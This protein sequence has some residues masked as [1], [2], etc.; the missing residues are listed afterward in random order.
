M[1]R[2]TRA[3]IDK[4][5]PFEDYL[6]H[7][8]KL[9]NQGRS[10]SQ[11]EKY[12]TEEVLGYTKLNLARMTRIFKTA[13]I[14]Q[15][16]IKS[17]STIPRV[18][19]W[20]VISESWCG[21]AAQSVPVMAKIASLSPQFEFGILLRDEHPELIDSF[22]TKGA[23]AIPK[24]ICLDFVTLK[25]LGDWG[26]RPKPAQEKMVQWIAEGLE[27]H[28]RVEQIQKW[29]N[30]DKTVSIQSELLAKIEEWS[31]LRF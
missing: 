15:N 17:F 18:W 23:R 9:F 11:D 24:L 22:L 13:D 29:Y 1:F 6:H 26:P 5:I 19:I 10:T 8:E 16:I 27:H 21:D 4:S 2:I 20:L 31:D 14:D 28:Q 12:N 7:S 25:I 30:E 3:L